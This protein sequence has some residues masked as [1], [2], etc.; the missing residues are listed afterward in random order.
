MS[1]ENEFVYISVDIK[2]AYALAGKTIIRPRV[3]LE[4]NEL[5]EDNPAACNSSEV[6]VKVRFD[7]LGKDA[8]ANIEYTIHCNTL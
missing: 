7:L 1:L 6:N 2:P 4:L 5:V 3:E 8:E